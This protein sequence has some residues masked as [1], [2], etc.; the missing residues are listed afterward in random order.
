MYL[1]SKAVCELLVLRKGSARPDTLHERQLL[2]A[3]VLGVQSVL[4]SVLLLLC[5]CG[6]A[7][8]NTE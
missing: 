5:T 2:D 1:C 3:T 7:T 6:I 4:D 8:M